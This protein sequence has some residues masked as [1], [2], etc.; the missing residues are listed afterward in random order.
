VDNSNPL[1][2][3]AGNPNLDQNFTHSTTARFV[4]TNIEKSTTFF[5][6]IRGSLSDNY[7]GNSTTIAARGTTSVNGI[8]LQPGAQLTQPVN[9][10]GYRTLR[11]FVS[12]GL[13]L[14][15]I[16]S[17][18]NF[19]ANFNYTRTPEL[20][21]DALNY[22]SSPTVG[23]GWVL[24]SNISEKIDFTLAS[25]SSYNT[26]NN[27]L[28]EVSNTNFFSQGTR[29]RLNWIFGNGIV[30]RSTV[31]HT[32]NSG[33]TD[34]FNQNF[35]LWNMEV[36]KKLFKQK[37]ELKLTVFDL[38]KENQ[39][40]SRTVNGSF[41]EDTQSQILTQYFMLTFTF[42]I[43]SFGLDQALPTNNRPQRGQNFRQG[44]GRGGNE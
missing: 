1:F 26:V 36:G 37:G 39:S 28:Q 41:I 22:S 15:G 12:Y 30:F 16:K 3:S 11:S 33:L 38:L 42:N 2:V 10:K 27:T 14:A 21:N 17:N 7:I 9:L 18:L 13:P 35:A 29:L 32:F 24:S 31:N 20:I 6:M 25:N 4:S 19:T 43:R 23:L 44:F 8:D 40:I 34:G 5:A